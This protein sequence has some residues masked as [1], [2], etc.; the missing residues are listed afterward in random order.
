[1]TCKQEAQSVTRPVSSL[2]RLLQSQ[3]RW[4]KSSRRVRDGTQVRQRQ[5]ARGPCRPEQPGVPWPTSLK[6]SILFPMVPAISP[7]TPQ[8]SD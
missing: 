2:H 7:W 5:D 4:P 6:T 1:M 3:G 8:G